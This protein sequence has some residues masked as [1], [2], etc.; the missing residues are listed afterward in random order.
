MGHCYPEQ[1]DP[2]ASPGPELLVSDWTNCAL[3]AER[4]ENLQRGAAE[5]GSALQNYS[6]LLL[7]GLVRISQSG[8]L[9]KY[10][11]MSY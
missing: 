9:W 8:V 2:D 7:K 10:S 4:G 5:R 11:I 6:A 1:A 3:V